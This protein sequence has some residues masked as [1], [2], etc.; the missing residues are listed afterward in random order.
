M[1]TASMLVVLTTLLVAGCSESGGFTV[2]Q[3][4]QQFDALFGLARPD[5]PTTKAI[6]IAKPF[7]PPASVELV[8]STGPFEAA[9]GQLPGSTGEGVLWSIDIVFTPT[10]PPPPAGTPI[11]GTITL[12]FVKV[13]GTLAVDLN[14]NLTA[15]VE[16]PRI[17][18]ETN[19]IA[20][21]KVAIGERPSGILKIN[22]PNTATPITVQSIVL[23]ADPQF[24]LD[25]STTPFPFDIL[26]GDDRRI[27]V[28][29][30][31]DALGTQSGSVTVSH[32]L[33]NPL[34]ATLSGEGM[35]GEL[36]IREFDD[37]DPLMFDSSGFVTF[38][39]TLPAEAMS[40]NIYALD[41]SAANIDIAYLEGP[42][43]GDKVF[44]EKFGPGLF[45]GPWLWYESMPNGLGNPWGG[46]LGSGSALSCQL[47][48]SDASEAQLVP[49]GGQY[50]IKFEGTPNGELLLRLTAEM[51]RSGAAAQGTLPLNILLAPSLSVDATTAPNDAKM[52]TVIAR[53]QEVLLA[54]GLALGP[55]HYYK[56]D[57]FGVFEYDDIADQDLL[58]ELLLFGPLDSLD[59]MGDPFQ[60]GDADR[61]NVFFVNSIGGG[62]FTAI[63]NGV[64]SPKPGP[65][66][67]TSNH[68]GIVIDYAGPLS[69][70]IG[71]T[72]ARF[73]CHACGLW[74]TVMTDGDTFDIIEDT[75]EC[76]LS[77]TTEE[78]PIEGNDNLLHPFDLGPQATK[79]T[80]GQRFVAVRNAFVAPG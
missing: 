57:D 51:R 73:I 30:A 6:T 12:R 50:E 44:T 8:Q 58:D 53:I 64:P 19:A 49:G 3:Q 78:C 67:V 76:P 80:G 21:G 38:K 35:V 11:T 9:P 79:L 47:P 2:A 20:F 4:A 77:G 14:L 7:V 39:F 33:G 17:D 25:L 69:D 46:S 26:P 62:A 55:V 24:A 68:S 16:E 13:D 22:N 31:P 37:P 48:N 66:F 70:E 18:L 36:I 29:Y 71:K 15:S 60:P 10:S 41:F 27:P 1:R 59:A 23:L 54:A 52:Q 75:P 65:V 40:L 34:I 61:L 42:S 32:N 72:T 63:T 28:I 43:P 74:P 56:I 5:A 45:T